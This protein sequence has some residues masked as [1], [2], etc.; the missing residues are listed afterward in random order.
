MDFRSPAVLLWHANRS[1]TIST[2]VEVQ[3]TAVPRGREAHV[4]AVRAED[5]WALV[6]LASPFQLQF[7]DGSVL[8][9][10]LG[11]PDDSGVFP[12]WEWEQEGDR[13]RPCPE[14]TGDLVRTDTVMEADDSIT[15]HDACSACGYDVVRHLSPR[16]APLAAELMLERRDA[17]TRALNG[18]PG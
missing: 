17:R 13:R 1:F 16:T 4:S 12:V 8:D 2:A 6:A 9:V 5:Y 18:W 3:A 14:C 11:D 10:G 7:E 15:L